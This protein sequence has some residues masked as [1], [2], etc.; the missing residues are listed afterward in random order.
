MKGQ[1]G[2][3]N[4]QEILEESEDRAARLAEIQATERWSPKRLVRTCIASLPTS[5][6]FGPM[7]AAEAQER[8]LYSASRRAFVAD[9][10]AYNWAIH[11]GYF[12]HFEPIVD[13]LPVLCYVYW[14][15]RAVHEKEPSGWSP[16]LVWM[17]ACW[18]GRV[19]EV[20]KELEVWQARLGTPPGSEP[21]TA[22]ERR[23]PRWLVASA[24]CYLTNNQDR[25]DYPRYRREGLPTTSS[26]V[27]SLVG[28]FNT[29]VK[30]RPKFWTRPT[31]AESILQVRAALLSQDDRMSRYFANRPGNPF[32]KKTKPKQ[33]DTLA[34]RVTP[35]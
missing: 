14:A 32:R 30:G 15:A 19:D 2:E 23:D 13:F 5:S 34:S 6:S 9:G 18:L 16:Y 12:A 24:R 21:K 1:A 35:I 25:M 20:L 31:G 7:M 33:K 28:E 27:E 29:R 8:N 10:Q 3:A 17:R 11:R 22:E 26:L 4:G